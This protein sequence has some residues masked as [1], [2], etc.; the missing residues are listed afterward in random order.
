MTESRTREGQGA[1]LG[2]RHRHLGRRAGL[3]SLLTLAS[4]LLGYAREAVTAALFGDRSAILDAFLT[5]WRIPNLFRR[6]FGE[7]AIATS[8]QTEF[9]EV[10]G[11][12]GE[13]AGRV[14]YWSV[15]KMLT[16][17]LVVLTLALTALVWVL[18]DQLGVP[19]L[20]GVWPLGRLPWLGPE[21][22]AVRELTVR[23]LPF[24]IVICLTAVTSAALHVRGM[25]GATALAPVVFNVVWIVTLVLLLRHFPD[26][27][28]RTAGSVQLDM[29][30]FLAWGILLAAVLQ[31]LSLVPS[32]LRCDLLGGSRASGPRASVAA[33]VQ[34]GPVRSPVSVLLRSL[35]LAVG[36]AVYQFNVMV[37]GVMAISLLPEGGAGAHYFATRVQQ[38]PMA[39]IAFAATTAV[40]PALKALGQQGDLAGL[41][42]LHS[43]TQRTVAFLALPAAAGL[44]TLAQPVV[45]TMF[46]HGAY[47]Q[48][49]VDRIVGALTALAIAVVPVG[50]SGL[51]VRCFYSVGDFRTPVVVSVAMMALNL[52][53]NLWFIVGLGLDTKGLALG[54][55]VTSWLALVLLVPLLRSRH[56]L[57][58]GPAGLARS[59]GLS[60]VGAVACGAV[61]AP[62]YRAMCGPLRGLLQALHLLEGD[63]QVRAS[64]VLGLLAAIVAGV[65]AHFA[66]TAALGSEEARA[67]LGRL[68]GRQAR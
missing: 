6:L 23:L 4:R 19:G 12:D 32:L 51:V 13:E 10:E 50:A 2:A 21:P 30:R 37:D 17:I 52:V 7:G 27:A 24:L 64:Q 31:G 14:F 61:A 54:T 62:A 18:P 11:G 49:G 40:F 38:F 8:F 25:F 44:I 48:G 36:A 26:P 56:R 43:R 16:T 45:M 34:H 9:S 39:M 68:R 58:A 66:V 3:V 29:V 42:R 65:A 1:D 28:V 53:L 5:A 47:E 35:P 59:V 20:T 46:M 60:A 41:S 22:A 55:A 67:F 63:S 57:P 15:L 33:A